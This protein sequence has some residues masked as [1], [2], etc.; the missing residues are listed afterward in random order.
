MATASLR[1]GRGAPSPLAVDLALAKV[2]LAALRARRGEGL[3]RPAQDAAGLLREHYSRKLRRARN[4][5]PLISETLV[6]DDEIRQALQDGL[7][8]MAN[9]GAELEQ[10][11]E[12]HITRLLELLS[13]LAEAGRC[14]PDEGKELHSL[15]HTLEAKP[16]A[17]LPAPE[18][19]KHDGSL[20]AFS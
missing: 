15:L 13:T 20:N 10:V 3:D 12:R 14:E 4:P 17:A 6:P 5:V 1:S 2:D 19:A 18:F 16:P 8:S 7:A 9:V 11:D